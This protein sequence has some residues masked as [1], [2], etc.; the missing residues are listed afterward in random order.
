MFKCLAYI[1]S[2][3]IILERTYA[4]YDQWAYTHDGNSH[5]FSFVL[6]LFASSIGWQSG[7][8][9]LCGI[10]ISIRDFIMSALMWIEND[11]ISSL[12][13]LK[14]L[15]T[16]TDDIQKYI[17][18]IGFSFIFFPSSFV[19]GYVLFI[20]IIGSPFL[21]CVAFF[22]IDWKW[23]WNRVADSIYDKL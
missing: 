14:L 15:L 16:C 13:S 19:C 23:N 18:R 21:F 5:F 20:I 9:W 17:S 3:L 4:Y 12:S 2:H 1:N 8:G 6:R 7:S 10:A 11:K 22:F